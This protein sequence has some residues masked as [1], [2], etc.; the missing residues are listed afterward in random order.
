MRVLTSSPTSKPQHHRL[1]R[2]WWLMPTPFSWLSSALYIGLLLYALAPA[3]PGFVRL[4]LWQ[5]PLIA[6]I[7]LGLL[8]LDRLEYRRYREQIPARMAALLIIVRVILILLAGMIEGFNFIP[9]LYLILPYFVMVSFGYKMGYGIAALV[10]L[11]YFAPMWWFQPGW[12]RDR[13]EVLLALLFVCGMVFVVVMARGI[14]L[15]KA[16]RVRAEELLVEVERAHQQLQ[17]YAERVAELATT[18]E[19]NRVARDIHDGLGHALMAISVQLEK[20]LVY[21]DKQPQ[22]AMQAISDAKRVAKDA[23]QDVRRSVRALRAEQEPFLCVQA[24][25]LLVERLREDSLAVNFEVTGGEESFS[26]AAR[27]TLYRVAQEGFTN[28]QKHA[29]ASRVEVSLHFTGAEARLCIRDDGHGFDTGRQLQQ[30]AT[31]EEG[32]GLRGIRERMELVGGSFH[33]ESEPGRGTQLS[34]MV[35][36]TG[37][38]ASPHPGKGGMYDI[39]ESGRSA[40]FYGTSAGS[41]RSTIDP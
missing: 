24:M 34:V 10:T 5:V 2:L 30:K 7:V 35:T 23:L 18:E 39:C 3:A 41:G 36:R 9:V 15:E 33:I 21:Y 29:Q 13:F 27:M 25:T 38:A 19:R 37:M 12:Y 8:L 31:S 20:A 22:E 6:I 16:S 11:L 4:A 14:L 32:Y 1:H 28:I 26:N 17:A 40:S